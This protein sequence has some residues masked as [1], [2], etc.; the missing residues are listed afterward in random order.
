MSRIYAG[1]PLE[2]TRDIRTLILQ[3]AP[4]HEEP[5][6]CDLK[7][8]SLE[9][10][11]EYEALSYTW[12]APFEGQT[13][14]HR[15]ITLCGRNFEVT[16]NLYT[17]L[18]RFR[19][20]DKPRVLWIDAVCIDQSNDAE[21]SAQVAIMSKIYAAASRVL[22]WLGEDSSSKDGYITLSVLDHLATAVTTFHMIEAIATSQSIGNRGPQYYEMV[23][24]R[25]LPTGLQFGELHSK[26][27]A[28]NDQS[29]VWSVIQSVHTFFNRRYF[30]R[31]WVV[32]EM[33]HAKT[34]IISCGA[35][36]IYWQRFQ[37]GL[38]RLRKSA[39]HLLLR[40][41]RRS[42]MLDVLQGTM[43]ERLAALLQFS[44]QEGFFLK[45]IEQCNGAHCQDPRDRIFALSSMNPLDWPQP[46]Y[47]SSASLVFTRFSEACVAH[48]HTQSVLFHA[49]RQ[50]ADRKRRGCRL[51]LDPCLPSWVLDWRDPGEIGTSFWSDWASEK[52]PDLQASID[53]PGRLSCNLGVLGTFAQGEGP[54]SGG[55]IL[56]KPY[57]A[58][59]DEHGSVVQEVRTAIQARCGKEISAGDILCR[60][61]SSSEEAVDEVDGLIETREWC[62]R[63]GRRLFENG[64]IFLRPARPG[65]NDHVVVPLNAGAQFLHR[66]LEWL[67]N[68]REWRRFSIV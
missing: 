22:I 68:D 42:E 32:Q 66:P 5:I 67:P 24:S 1:Y 29:Y 55:L 64:I 44:K 61:P 58:T 16:G 3:P 37:R 39:S 26:L 45:C 34:A 35:H 48:N 28:P 12:G 21:R 53:A 60:L 46:D 27:D 17:A 56:Q 8:I 4:P 25:L 65:T 33:Y 50:Q 38:D 43:I 62:R 49:A 63:P 54:S 7:V 15:H 59:Y 30:R 41:T 2:H 57:G 10:P 52:G 11:D 19:T 51:E 36:S 14:D 6:S 18:K 47:S 13:L 20:Q 23:M 9:E 40:G 31:L